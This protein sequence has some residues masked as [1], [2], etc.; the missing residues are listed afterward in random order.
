[1]LPPWAGENVEHQEIIDA[2]NRDAAALLSISEA[3]SAPTR[4]L[5]VNQ[6]EPAVS[7]S[8]RWAGVT[9]IAFEIDTAN[10]RPTLSALRR[11]SNTNL[12]VSPQRKV[13]THGRIRASIAH[14]NAQQMDDLIVVLKAVGLTRLHPD[15]PG[16]HADRLSQADL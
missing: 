16:P 6:L 10:L 9:H 3:P 14:W 15:E 4:W 7:A 8:I 11:I 12:L 1:V 2:R 5:W 13:Q